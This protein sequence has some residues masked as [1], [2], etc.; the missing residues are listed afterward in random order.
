MGTPNQP[1]Q[2]SSPEAHVD[3]LR[4][5]GVRAG[6]D[7][8]VGR[9]QGFRRAVA[10]G[11]CRQRRPRTTSSGTEWSARRLAAALRRS[12]WTGIEWKEIG[13]K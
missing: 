12:P 2:Q 4:L 8:N 7:T 5:V 3:V 6:S 10:K 1:K 13:S 11:R 9:T